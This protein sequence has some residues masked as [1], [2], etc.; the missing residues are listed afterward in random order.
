MRLSSAAFSDDGELPVRYTRDGQA[1]APPV[2]WSDL[3]DGTAELVLVM[4]G[5]TPSTKPPFIHWCVYGIAPDL[6]G[7]PEG[8]MSKKAP[9]DPPVLQALTDA[10]MTGY[11]APLGTV[12]RR[13]DFHLRLLALDRKLDMEPGADAHTVLA[14]AEAHKIGEAALMV[15]YTRSR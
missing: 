9:Q 8:L 12:N 4:E 14:A 13:M 11:D 5:L 7:L 15:H 10:D 6:D 1:F 2:Q 3:P